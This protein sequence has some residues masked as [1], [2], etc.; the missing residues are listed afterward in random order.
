LVVAAFVPPRCGSAAFSRGRAP[1]RLRPWNRPCQQGLVPPMWRA[2]PSFSVS[3]PRGPRS[4]RMSPGLPRCTAPVG[5]RSAA[6]LALRRGDH[7]TGKTFDRVHW[8]AGAE[9][10]P[11]WSHGPR[12]GEAGQR[13]ARLRPHH[14]MAVLATGAGQTR[15][16][17]ECAATSGRCKTFPSEIR[18]VLTRST[19]LHQKWGHEIS[20]SRSC[21][22]GASGRRHPAQARR[23]GRPRQLPVPSG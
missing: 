23:G 20:R 18:N 16:A 3:V 9:T 11:I 12:A 2:Y 13:R 5:T 21:F 8:I 15:C 22:R 10:K 1:G 14:R 17:P 19:R 6:G 7:Q 4:H